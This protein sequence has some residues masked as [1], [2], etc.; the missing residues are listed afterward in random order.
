MI[1]V[2]THITDMMHIKYYQLSKLLKNNTDR[3]AACFTL[4]YVLR[5]FNKS[6]V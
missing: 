2:L 3:L 1:F 6:S 5:K 4:P